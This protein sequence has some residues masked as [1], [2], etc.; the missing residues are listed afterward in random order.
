MKELL[1]VFVLRG[2]I[3]ARQYFQFY[4]ASQLQYAS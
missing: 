3:F 2:S 4:V 1:F